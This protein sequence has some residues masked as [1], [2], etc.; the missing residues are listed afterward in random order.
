MNGVDFGIYPA[1]AEKR[2]CDAIFIDAR[3]RFRTARLPSDWHSTR[4]RRVGLPAENFLVYIFYIGFCFFFFCCSFFSFSFFFFI[5]S[6]P[7]AHCCALSY[8][9]LYCVRARSRIFF[10]FFYRFIRA[11]RSSHGRVIRPNR[12]SIHKLA[13]D[14]ASPATATAS[15]FRVFSV[16]FINSSGSLYTYKN[17]PSV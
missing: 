7:P 8:V 10:F 5:G 17:I 4:R 13:D 15:P 11:T 16:F 6:A 9:L 2:M 3:R 14:R 12:K 1:F